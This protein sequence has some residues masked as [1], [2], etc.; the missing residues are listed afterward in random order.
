LVYLKACNEL[1]VDRMD[2][3]VFVSRLRR[4]SLGVYSTNE[5]TCEHHQLKGEE[6]TQEFPT[7]KKAY[8][9]F[10]DRAS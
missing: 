8:L 5:Q 4:P 1:Q 9:M 7:K 3:E 10:F 2:A 6:L